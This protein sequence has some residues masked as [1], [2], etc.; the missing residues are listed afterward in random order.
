MVK[1]R[2]PIETAIKKAKEFYQDY[3]KVVVDIDRDIIAVGGEFHIDCEEVLINNGSKLENLYG[4][5]YRISTKEVEY[6]AMS[7]FKP[8]LGKTMY[9]IADPVIRDKVYTLTKKY[10]EI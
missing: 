3:I 9:E 1:L 7:N 2:M 10:L 5:G 8:N 6:M 4:G